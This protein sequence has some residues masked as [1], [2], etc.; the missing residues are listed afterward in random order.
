MLQRAFGM[1]SMQIVQ[2]NTG[3]HHRPNYQHLHYLH[4]GTAVEAAGPDEVPGAVLRHLLG[5]RQQ[6]EL[7]VLLRGCLR[8]A[9]VAAIEQQ[10]VAILL[11]T[12]SV[13]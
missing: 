12:T 10:V 1:L 7:V 6:R 2:D 3:F 13:C 5:Q 11:C 9:M 8:R 4:G